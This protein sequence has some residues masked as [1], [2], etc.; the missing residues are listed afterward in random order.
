MA[1]CLIPVIG[2]TVSTRMS[3]EKQRPN[4][5]EIF[6][7]SMSHMHNVKPTWRLRPSNSFVDVAGNNTR[8]DAQWSKKWGELRTNAIECVIFGILPN[9]QTVI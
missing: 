1:L 4:E 3:A 9:E 7:T 6:N 8:K 5:S 2:V